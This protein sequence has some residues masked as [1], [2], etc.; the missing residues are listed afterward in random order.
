MAVMLIEV[1][2]APDAMA[3]LVAQAENRQVQVE[4]M[5]EVAGCKLLGAWYLNGTHR[6]I[7]IAEGSVDDVNAV[8]LVALGSRS[9]TACSV[10]QLTAFSSARTYFARAL[11][12]RKDVE[13]QKAEPSFLRSGT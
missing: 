7:F 3:A 4:R 12:I 11:A 8:A 9:L 10:T 6:A 1:G 2:Y 5:F 13:E